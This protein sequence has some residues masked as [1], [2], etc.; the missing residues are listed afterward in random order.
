MPGVWPHSPFIVYPST[1][2]DLMSSCN[3][4]PTHMAKTPRSRPLIDK[5]IATRR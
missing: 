5:R 4:D 1:P 3:A 2:T